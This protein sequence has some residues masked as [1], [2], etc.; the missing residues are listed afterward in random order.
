MGVSLKAF[1]SNISLVSQPNLQTRS[2]TADPLAT[3]D[4]QTL[5]H[6]DG[7]PTLRKPLLISNIAPTMDWTQLAPT[8]HTTQSLASKPDIVP[9]TAANSKKPSKS[10]N[11]APPTKPAQSAKVAKKPSDNHNS[12]NADRAQSLQLRFPNETSIPAEITKEDMK[13]LVSQFE[14]KV[15]KQM[16]FKRPS[17]DD[18]ADDTKASQMIPPSSYKP[19]QRH[20]LSTV[21][22]PHLQSN[23]TKRS[24]AD[25]PPG[26]ASSHLQNS[27]QLY[28]GFVWGKAEFHTTSD[29]PLPGSSQ[30]CPISLE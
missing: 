6:T 18:L 17:R 19:S 20:F 9:T 29:S 3:R 10:G 12:A 1:F 16:N 25:G 7:A 15:G 14:A 4:A 24:P 13:R 28:N 11:T 21:Q 26:D 2:L 8:L 5:T 30:D 27:D 23:H 22:P